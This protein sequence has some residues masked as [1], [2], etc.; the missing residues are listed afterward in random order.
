MTEFPIL[1]SSAGR[2]V[3]LLDLLRADAAALGLRPVLIAT[4]AAPAFSAAC[5][6]ADRAIAVPPATH[7][8]FPGTML[9]I[10]RRHGV[11]LLVPTIDPELAPIAAIA[12]SLRANATLV[13]ISSPAAIAIARDKLL[14]ARA[15]GADAPASAPPA[16]VL[17]APERWRF[18]LLAKPRGGSAST[19]V[20]RIDSLDAVRGLPDGYMVQQLLDGVEYTVN[21][22]VRAD[23]T[24]AAVPH[25]RREVRAGEVAKAITLRHPGLAAI[26]GRLPAALPG[27]AGAVCFQAIETA[28]GARVIEVNARFG[29]GFPIA[30]RAG[31]PFTRWLIEQAAALPSSVGDG[32]QE[33]VT[34]L[35]YDAAIFGA[36][37]PAAWA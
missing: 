4:D 2:R 28:D 16:G 31:A 36:A 30:H 20:Q 6:V 22:F 32:W 37:D 25:R 5:A 3:A 17:A 19:G 15:L 12:D 23:R 24:L 27:L 1:V 26:A 29:G 11:R 10:C 9:A 21:L 34:M 18:P 13:N 8:E 33:G 35:R 7:G 14:T